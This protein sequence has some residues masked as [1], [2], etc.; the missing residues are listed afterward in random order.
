MR[1]IIKKIDFFF[2][3]HLCHTRSLNSQFINIS[4]EGTFCPHGDLVQMKS[5]VAGVICNLL[6]I[7]F[8]QKCLF[9]ASIPLLNTN[10]MLSDCYFLFTKL[11]DTATKVASHHMML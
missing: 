2:L 11:R 8:P 10:M 1:T 9:Y 5:N 6:C 4:Y 7:L 3:R